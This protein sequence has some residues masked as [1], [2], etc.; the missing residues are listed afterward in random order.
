MRAQPYWIEGPWKGGLAILPRPRGGDWLEDEISAWQESG[1]DVVVSLLA[2]DEVA[3]FDLQ[4]ENALSEAYGIEFVSFPIPDRGVPDSEAAA[5][6]LVHKL[7]QSLA[8]GEKIAV[9]CRQGIGRS[10]LIAASLLV[11][12]GVEPKTAFDRVA[13]ARGSSVPDT[14]EQEEWVSERTAAL[15]VQP[16]R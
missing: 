8:S 6:A 2:P 11:A 15:T 10:A 3:E 7:D 5:I 16:T 9:H 12:S 4:A 13:A 1:I 14:P